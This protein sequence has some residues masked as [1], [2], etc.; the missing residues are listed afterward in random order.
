MGTSDAVS[1]FQDVMSNVANS[2]L[3][4]LSSVIF[5]EAIS[6]RE[7]QTTTLALSV[8]IFTLIFY[9]IY[10]TYLHPLS[11]F[12][13]PP[14]ARY[15]PSWRNK[16]YWR[17]T[18]HNDILEVH[19]KYGNVV[20]IAPNELSI[21][22]KDASK[23]LFGHGTTSTKTHWYATFD[24]PMPDVTSLFST[25]D[26]KYHAFLR[27]RISGAYAMSSIL[28]YEVF[29]QQSL[30][31]LFQKFKSHSESEGVVDIA[32][33]TNAFAFDVV[34]QLGFGAPLGHIQTEK[35]VMNIRQTIFDIFVMSVGM[36]H[37]YAGIKGYYWGQMTI[38]TN[39]YTTALMTLLG[40]KNPME[41]FA[42]YGISKIQERITAKEKGDIGRPDMLSHFLEM[43]RPDGSPAI[44]NEIMV[45]ALTLVY[46]NTLLPWIL[47][48]SF[49]LDC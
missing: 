37:Y 49:P 44:F 9:A 10:Q 43:K 20:R 26:K 7:R 29:I 12:P 36:G 5:P 11:K 23:Q 30:N 17:G 8:L 45:D 24:P 14:S 13:G 27:K 40:Q 4:R 19:K 42:Q 39:K 1:T 3:L 46:V 34:G 2:S 16:R 48:S 21:V 22:D 15:L 47:F 6:A 33:W 18:W 32:E 31:E 38:F 28:K 41:D 35:D 25:C